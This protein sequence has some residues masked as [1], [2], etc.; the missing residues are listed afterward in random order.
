MSIQYSYTHAYRP[1]CDASVLVPS[2]AD[3]VEFDFK[4][5]VGI[6]ADA[7]A[8]EISAAALSESGEIFDALEFLTICAWD[9]KYHRDEAAKAAAPAIQ[10]AAE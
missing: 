4:A 5:A 1:R 7:T 8:E 3:A 10:Q 2:V 6:V 9:V